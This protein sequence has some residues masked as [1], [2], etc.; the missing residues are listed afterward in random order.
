MGG[1]VDEVGDADL[2]VQIEIA[3]ENVTHKDF[4]AIEAGDSLKGCVERRAGA[5][6]VEDC[7]EALRAS[8]GGADDAFSSQHAGFDLVD[9]GW[10]R[11]AIDDEAVV[12]EVERGVPIVVVAGDV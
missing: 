11:A 8:A 3:D 12:L 6:V 1:Q 5:V 4:V 7:G 2:A 9:D 10:E